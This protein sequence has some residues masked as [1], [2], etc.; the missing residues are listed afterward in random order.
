MSK[1][2]LVIENPKCCES[3]RLEFMGACHGILPKRSIAGTPKDLREK[4]SW[5]PLVLVSK[6]KGEKNG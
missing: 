4:P 6:E 1:V 5:C 2:A 3:C